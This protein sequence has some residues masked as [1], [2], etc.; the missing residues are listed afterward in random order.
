MQAGTQANISSRFV[1]TILIPT[2]DSADF[3]TKCYIML[4]LQMCTFPG[5]GQGS[6][7][8][9]KLV[10]PAQPTSTAQN[11]NEPATTGLCLHLMS[12]FRQLFSLLPS[13]T[14]L[15]KRHKSSDSCR[16]AKCVFMSVC[17]RER[18]GWGRD[19]TNAE[20]LQSSD[21]PAPD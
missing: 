2:L 16:G 14:L 3:L 21:G 4:R 9:P 15:D 17:E 5:N 20:E 13:N 6:H 1:P 10:T 7:Q 19:R 8:H 12:G 18:E 11:Q